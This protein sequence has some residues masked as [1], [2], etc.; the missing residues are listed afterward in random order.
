MWTSGVR[1]GREHDTS[2][3]RADPDLLS[4]ITD[5]TSNE[6]RALADLG[7]EGESGTFVVPFKKPNDGKLTVDQ[8]S[9]N[10]LHSGL[11]C[12]GERANSLLKTSYKALRRYRGCPWRLGEIVAAALV[13]LHHQHDRT[14]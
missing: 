11:R 8:Q 12:L 10:A 5:W 13:L 9:F 1:P 6:R 7:Y 3:A 14:T 2:A 4:R